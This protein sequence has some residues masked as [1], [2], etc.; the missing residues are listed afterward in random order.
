MVQLKLKFD[1]PYSS[2]PMEEL[3]AYDKQII[4]AYRR[5]YT[6]TTGLKK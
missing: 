1:Q 4:S 2:I 5:I 6:K 3:T